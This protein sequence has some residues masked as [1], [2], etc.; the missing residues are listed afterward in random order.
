MK[1]ENT[2]NVENFFLCR[3]VGKWLKE[4]PQDRR[5]RVTVIEKKQIP[6]KWRKLQPYHPKMATLKS[7]DGRQNVD[8]DMEEMCRKFY[9]NLFASCVDVT[10]PQIHTVKQLAPCADQRRTEWSLPNEE[11]KSYR[12]QLH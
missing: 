7:E 6:M 8:E 9:A 1:T 4:D 12:Q 10:A 2:R 5:R 11:Q 3:V